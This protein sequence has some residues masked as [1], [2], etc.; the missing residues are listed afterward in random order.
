MKPVMMYQDRL[1]YETF[2]VCYGSN[3]DQPLKR[4]QSMFG[5]QKTWE[6]MDE[7]TDKDYLQ[8]Q[9][10]AYKKYTNMKRNTELSF[11]LT[12]VVLSW[13]EPEIGVYTTVPGFAYI[14]IRKTGL[15]Q[16]LK[17]DNVQNNFQLGH[18]WFVTDEPISYVTYINMTMIDNGQL[19]VT[20]FQNCD[21]PDC[22]F[23]NEFGVAFHC[24]TSA[25]QTM[26]VFFFIFFAVMIMLSIALIVLLI[27]MK[28][29][30]MNISIKTND[31]GG[32]TNPAVYAMIICIL[33]CSCNAA[34]V[35]DYGF[36]MQSSMIDCTEVNQLITCSVN[37]KLL[38]NFPY[39]GLT[40]CFDVFNE[41]TLVRTISF[42]WIDSVKTIQTNLAYWTGPWTPIQTFTNGC[43]TADNCKIGFNCESL[44]GWSGSTLA[45]LN[46][47][48]PGKVSMIPGKSFC[49]QT[50]GCVN[51]GCTSCDQSCLWG[52]CAFATTAAWKVLRPVST[53]S[54][55]S[56]EICSIDS[57]K[58]SSCTTTVTSSSTPVSIQG[59]VFSSLSLS[60]SGSSYFG[61]N[62]FIMS[63]DLKTTYFGTAAATG[64]P[65]SQG[66][67]DIQALSASA[68]KNP[69]INSFTYSY[70]IC[71]MSFSGRKAIFSFLKSGF[72]IT[73]QMPSL[74]TLING[75]TW[76]VSSSGVISG[77]SKP[78]NPDSWFLIN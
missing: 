72:D 65:V 13:R 17:C 1:D 42:K 20:S 12:P 26:V 3:W 41:G 34:P 67:G 23:C 22:I 59:G 61:S 66:I 27:K 28:T 62:A 63:E 78:W 47:Q 9:R 25:L 11:Q 2:T 64:L 55:N 37:G 58:V 54:V 69:N 50:C 40:L 52:R 76:M 77:G 36:S 14:I 33:I 5:Q 16:T 44:A 43:A 56:F 35:C 21:I 4:F 31:L 7:S 8:Y 71:D 46:N 18:D 73:T 57:N 10:N 39:P 70:D 68:I 53:S 38:L 6:M 75:I 24:F 19:S 30:G 60:Q 32:L 48:F 15:S 74:P 51:C 29:G 49:Q 45:T